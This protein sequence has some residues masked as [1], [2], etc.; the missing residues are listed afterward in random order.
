MGTRLGLIGLL[1]GTVAT[2]GAAQR[3]NAQLGRF[4][5][6]GMD[7]APTSA[8]RGRAALVRANRWAAI[9]RGDIGALNGQRA[10]LSSGRPGGGAQSLAVTGTFFVPVIAIA[11]NNVDVAYPL[12]DFQK[13]LFGSPPPDQRPFTLKSYYEQVSNGR[14]RMDGRVFDAVR[15]DSSNTYYENGCNGIGVRTACPDNGQRFGNML[16]AILDSVSNR[17]GG[18]TVW[19]QFDNDGPDG[20]PNS[21]D[22]D[23]D[24]DFVTFLQPA[25][26]GA[27]GA[28]GVWAHR[29]VVAAWNGGSKYVTKTPQRNVSGQ[30]IPGSF[31]RVNNYTIQ[32]QVGGASGCSGSFI[33]PIGTVSHE[34]GHAFGLPDL[35]DTD[36]TGSGTE[37]LG[38]WGI[39]GSGNYSRAYSPT[40][41]DAWSLNE[42]GWVTVDTL[43][44]S[45]TI[46]TG[47]RQT[48]DTIFLA[49]LEA[50]NELMLIENRQAVESDTAALNINAGGTSATC[51]SNCRKGPGLLLWHIDLA[52]IAQG[53]GSNRVNTGSIQGVALE[54]ADGLNNLRSNGSTRNRGDIGDPYPGSTGN[55]KWTLT[56]QPAALSNFGEYAGFVVDRIETLPA[57]VMRFR[58]LRRNPTV[59]RSTLAGASI[60]VNDELVGRFE[61]VIA[62]GEALR[63]DVD[64]VQEVLSGRSRGRFLAWSIGGPRQQVV[65]SGAKPD[66][67]S[68]SFA[69]DHR[70]R[71]VETGTG[72]GTVTANRP[73]SLSTGIFVGAGTPVGLVAAPAAGSVFVGWR[74]DTTIAT[75]SIT[76]PM[77]RP[78]DLEASFILDLQVP[79]IDATTEIL[80]TVKLTSDQ[81]Q[82]LDQLGNR[83]G[84]YDV[85]DFLALLKR[86][87]QSVS[88]ELLKALAKAHPPKGTI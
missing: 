53:R 25:V 46:T 76:V 60:R 85:G 28:P 86:S 55:T 37:G 31:I 17:A 6:P 67:I 50:N 74:G 33:M 44:A 84:L 21:G 35:Y 23:G 41:Y 65:I 78:Y 87:G 66:T 5:V 7:W 64:S 62:A 54:Q 10:L 49:R 51:R 68:A 43:G 3:P 29:F 30:P 2:V 12:P 16:I 38:E 8:W 18:D 32:S 36:P 24:V 73:G 56:T 48:T 80:G 22:D 26:D 77:G 61:D 47:P 75:G 88:P 52:R 27:C 83:N 59:V 42:L 69:A 9:Q 14:I 79:V 63:L 1:A 34:T 13:V 57:G 20:L 71:V 45:R 40:G 15:V 39:M 58:F 19:T 11:Y 4:E 82:F 72:L 70:L 81:K